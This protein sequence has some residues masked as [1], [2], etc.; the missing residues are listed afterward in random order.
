MQSQ[1]IAKLKEQALMLEAA[2]RNL[3]R[4]NESIQRELEI[5][6]RNQSQTSQFCVELRMQGL[7]FKAEVDRRTAV[8]LSSVQSRFGFVPP[9]IQKQITQLRILK[10][11][12]S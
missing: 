2:N 11:I 5:A 8:V 12:W 1:L 4:S 9:C 7:D 6:A 3:V 10:V